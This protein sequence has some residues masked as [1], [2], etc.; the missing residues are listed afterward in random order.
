MKKKYHPKGHSAITLLDKIYV[1]GGRTRSTYFD[2]VLIFDGTEWTTSE[3]S[4]TAPR[5]GH[6]SIYK[7]TFS[8]QEM[9]M[10]I[11]GFDEMFFEKWEISS[12][13]TQMNSTFSTD[14]YSFY[15]EVFTVPAGTIGKN[16]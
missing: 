13:I 12:S 15:P 14:N 10:Q 8:G 3:T 5:A 4:L 7:K 16:C 6:R 9:V 2:A 11:G 1:F